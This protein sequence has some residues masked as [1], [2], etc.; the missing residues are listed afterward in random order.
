MMREEAAA[1]ELDAAAFG[2]RV[3]VAEADAAAAAEEEEEAEKIKFR[4]VAT[5]DENAAAIKLQSIQRGR[6]ARAK[7]AELRAQ[8]L[9][10]EARASHASAKAATEDAD[11]AEKIAAEANAA[12]DA[13]IDPDAPPAEARASDPNASDEETPEISE[14]E[15]RRA[16]AVKLQAM[17]RGRAARAKLKAEHDEAAA[18]RAAVEAK[19]L[20]EEA[21]DAAFD[22]TEEEHTAA[23]KLQAVQ[24]GRAARAEVE[25]L[26][27]ER[28]AALEAEKAT[29]EKE[30]T[31]M[32]EGS[33]EQHA[34]ATKI[35]ALARG[36]AA[37][38]GMQRMRDEKDS[39]EAASADSEAAML[40]AEAE[41]QAV[42]AELAEAED[43]AIAADE[44]E[45][46]VEEYTGEED[47]DSAAA[48]MDVIRRG[49]ECR[50]AVAQ[51]KAKK[52][53]CESKCVFVEVHVAAADVHAA[54]AEAVIVNADVEPEMRGSDAIQIMI[55]ELQETQR[56]FAHRAK[57][58]SEKV[59]AA[60]ML[61][62]IDSRLCEVQLE[63]VS[64]EDKNALEM[65]EALQSGGLARE[66]KE[67]LQKERE[68]A[69]IIVAAAEAA[70]AAALEGTDEENAVDVSRKDAVQ[71]G[72]L[73][74][75]DFER[76]RAEHERAYDQN[77]LRKRPEGDEMPRTAVSVYHS[78]GFE[79]TKRNN[80]HYIAPDV[81]VF[82]VGNEVQT[83]HLVT[84]AQTYLHGVDGKGVGMVCVH[85]SK[86][87]LAVGE[88]GT[89]PNVYVYEY[90]RMKLR[91]IMRGGTE[92]S[93]ACGRFSPDGDTLATVGGF[94][95]FWLTL[96]DW[97]TESIVLR[98]KAFSQDVFDVQ[99]SPFFPGQLTTSG[100]GHVR[101]WKMAE[102][103][104]GLK[105]QGEIG[106]FGNEDLSDIAGYAELPDGKVLS[107]TES[108]RMLLWDGGLIKAVLL[109]PG[110]D[111][112]EG[113]PCHDGMIEVVRLVGDV[114]YTAAADGYV[115]TWSFA[116]VNDAE[117]GE[118]SI[119][120]LVEPI[121]ELLI[122][123]ANDAPVS[124][125]SVV[126]T[127][128]DHWLVQDEDGA[129]VRV[130]LTETG[131]PS[132]S[133]QL[134]SFHA[135]AITGLEAF[136]T[137]DHAVTCGADGTVRCF[138]YV[139]KREL[140]SVKS[141]APAS[142]NSLLPSHVDRTGR[143]VIA[144]Y[145]DGVV[146]VLRRC[147]DGWRLVDCVKPHR[148][149]VTTT[150]YSPNGR[151]LA[152][153]SVDGAVFFLSTPGKG[154]DLEPIG[155]VTAPGPVSVV[156]WSPCG[157]KVL[158]G[159]ETGDI[160][161]VPAP[162]THDASHTFEIACET[163]KYVFDRPRPTA[164]ELVPGGGQDLD[165]ADA[166]DRAKEVARMQAEL[167]EEERASVYPVKTLS[168]VKNSEEGWFELTVGGKATGKIFTCGFDN[169]KPHE[170]K[171]T[172]GSC[173]TSQSVSA[174]GKL[175]VVGY[176]DGTV[177]ARKDG[178]KTY[179][180]GD[181][182][183]AGYGAVTG[184]AISR[185]DAF[186]LSTSMDGSF[187]VQAL[188]SEF[189]SVVEGEGEGSP[190]KKAKELEA[191]ETPTL[192]EEAA[193]ALEKEIPDVTDI[194]S[195]SVYS[196]EEDKQKAEQD[197]L[198]AEAEAKK[199]GVKGYL[200]KLKGEFLELL[201]E[202]ESKPEAER[203]PLDAFEVDPGLRE[204]VE[205]ETKEKIARA[206]R[207][208]A[209]DKERTEIALQKL[210][211]KF[212]D[213]VQV[214]RV[215]LRS[216]AEGRKAYS[217]TSCRV[218][219]LSESL[220]EEIAKAREEEANS[221][222]GSP[223]RAQAQPRTRVKVDKNAPV[224]EEESE[225]DGDDENKSKYEL[226]RKH[227][228]AREKEWK[229]FN[230]T[231]PD[232][233][234]ENP[235]DVAAIATAKATLGDFKLKSDPDFLVAEDQR[236]DYNRKKRQMLFHE[237]AVH[238]MKM[239][240]NEKF[241]ALRDV[242][243][244]IVK[245]VVA[246]AK[247]VREITDE[248]NDGDS[249]EAVEALAAIEG[250]FV[251]TP[252]ADEY[253][254]EARG[255]VTDAQ[256]NAFAKKKAAEAAAK[257]AASSLGGFGGGGGDDDDDEDADADAA[258][259]TD[260]KARASNP[261]ADANAHAVDDEAAD[262]RKSAGD[263]RRV[264]RQNYPGTETEVKEFECLALALKHERA[265]LVQRRQ[266]LL[267]SFDASL[268]ELR[269]EK[270]ALE[271]ECKTADIK[272]LVLLEELRQLKLFEKREKTLL[273]KIEER[274]AEKTELENKVFEIECRVEEKA[275]ELAVVTE[276]KR[277]VVKEFGG[278]VPEEHAHRE[279][280]QKVFTKRVRRAKKKEEKEE[281][282]E[283]DEDSNSDDDDDSEYEDS[284]EEEEEAI[285]TGCDE[286]LWNA[287]LEIR[288]R[289]QDEDDVIL[290]IN[291]ITETD[292]KERDFLAKK[293]SNVLTSLKNTEREMEAF[294]KEKQN[295][296]NQIDVPVTLRMRQMSYLRNEKLPADLS[297]GLY[298]SRAALEGL[299]RRIDELIDEKAAL[300]V[301]QRD[302]R[303][304]NI[305]LQ[306][307]CATRQDK[308]DVLDARATELQMLKFGQ[309]V[310]LDALEA[311]SIPKKGVPELREQMKS[312]EMSNREEMK[313]WSKRIVDA[314]DELTR[315]TAE[316]TACLNAVADLTKT[317]R[318]LNHELKTSEK[319]VFIDPDA[320]RRKDI[321][322][323]DRLVEVINAQANEIE[324]LRSE[325]NMLSFKGRPTQRVYLS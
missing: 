28:E 157:T 49:R 7:V 162:E 207:E 253:P 35:Q 229:A 20:T 77:N 235:V 55:K 204:M 132:T 298:F 120:V 85:P 36:R 270:S 255:V 31:I 167:D 262:A 136:T 111:D 146:R 158:V 84:G 86:R 314:Q 254:T 48:K 130:E 138:D 115:K 51:L 252:L 291:K 10:A 180:H 199:L 168:Y 227:R 223:K 122:T 12:A 296:L 11:A 125:K 116:S 174:S 211:A 17:Q 121:A 95:D 92:R 24:R 46:N 161:E 242:R 26:K 186:V 277:K 213:P 2:A 104:T 160:V 59:A 177:R 142:T 206:H 44:E 63:E 113:K 41:V 208:F 25:R 175:R 45:L 205:A 324:N 202:N 18:K 292:R 79:S 107:G 189:S 293:L 50:F 4:G 194:T 276:N 261:A 273:G 129:L 9:A 240:F 164:E 246:G 71:R 98:S 220:L 210:R 154:I 32:F 315:M 294:Q 251:A 215:V 228:K 222:K 105:L 61:Q 56:S 267:T 75:E 171:T 271:Y 153:G 127:Q 319:T 58:R 21:A 100:T 237:E 269:R 67:R 52:L 108:G 173:I 90:P 217:V 263:S 39:A 169:P 88:K 305:D 225:D 69:A 249:P 245:T 134:V 278:L 91:K 34:A 288:E 187:F 259:E 60:T 313:Q 279:Y 133:E 114:I 23:T 117:P 14:E 185:D 212:L 272:Q 297:E 150:A 311:A 241:F 128:P 266:R 184:V 97:R 103:F 183:D 93:Y 226:R 283:S 96:W 62:R 244:D 42:V 37:R 73:A 123:K 303:G 19:L 112:G 5:D 191:D 268:R 83:L 247:R 147:A 256:L 163:T 40:A 258:K 178:A 233:E 236:V 139:G 89:D 322:E 166:K 316:N 82:T 192:A 22:G 172:H 152:T 72:R 135:G 176:E 155:F 300:R 309:L 74:R 198:R 257:E 310:D 265:S 87:I 201:R 64:R 321:A 325:L 232:P 15:A 94:P 148:D 179:W 302:L 286:K 284:D 197:K 6:A 137:S 280:L 181:V 295:S 126:M 13:A 68:D 260:A 274:D 308:I 106:R 317:Q 131:A 145:D 209:W 230:A 214:E 239:K 81:V 119:V 306:N 140:F 238:A 312:L 3:R 224:E 80:L 54:D 124:V 143:C 141:C 156:T 193:A 231:K 76:R 195:T 165:P 301:Q 110:G 243:A 109:V 70:L 200:E 219:K 264:E 299:Q 281:V 250:H 8:Q 182:H 30:M 170:T 203:L 285:P 27:I 102:T 221:V 144:G 218:A 47:E 234:E 188:G 318:D 289:R 196:I 65:Y 118:D 57:L 38:S 216:F 290:E 323:R 1:A 33:K 159:C 304:T 29:E 16:A 248:L 190:E 66:E 78:F 282:A 43:A 149:E 320:A 275:E 101:F 287:V 99:F 151:T 53:E 307:A